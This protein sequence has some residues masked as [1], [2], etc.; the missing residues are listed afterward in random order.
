MIELPE[1]N[2][3]AKQINDTLVGKI[4]TSVVASTIA[5]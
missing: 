5:P 2:T 4:I 3:L 1:A